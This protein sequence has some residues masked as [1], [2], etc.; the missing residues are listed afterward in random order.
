V[1][2][3][4]ALDRQV[5]P[6]SQGELYVKM[7][8][9]RAV[10]ED[11]QVAYGARLGVVQQ[12]QARQVMAWPVAELAVG[13]VQAWPEPCSGTVSTPCL[14]AKT[15]ACQ[16][17]ALVPARELGPASKLI[18]KAPLTWELGSDRKLE[19]VVQKRELEVEAEIGAQ[20]RV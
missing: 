14:E 3:E 13:V 19:T 2:L 5:A 11:Q 10:L 18:P 15:S 16:P 4:Q 7:E 20:L 6:A 12:Q 1:L 9:V 8:L 17:V